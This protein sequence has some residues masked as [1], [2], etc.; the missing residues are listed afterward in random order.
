MKR[1]THNNGMHPT[2]A[3]TAFIKLNRAGG[4]VMPGVRP[5]LSLRAWL[6]LNG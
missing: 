6:W 1:P 4:R 3:T 5:L 2:R